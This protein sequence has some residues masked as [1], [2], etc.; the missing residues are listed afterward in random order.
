M[1]YSNRLNTLE[2]L[3]DHCRS[4]KEIYTARIYGFAQDK[5]Q[6]CRVYMESEYMTGY[7]DAEL[8]LIMLIVTEKSR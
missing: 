4:E 7:Q 2:K 3:R 8:A 5:S 6:F 1:P